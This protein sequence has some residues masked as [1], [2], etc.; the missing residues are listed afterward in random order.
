MIC[1]AC[2][3]VYAPPDD[4][5]GRVETLA[6]LCPTCGTEPKYKRLGRASIEGLIAGSV[7][8]EFL[9]L[10]MFFSNWLKALAYPIFIA[11]LCGAI[12]AI[13]MRSEVI[14]FK[15]EAERKRHM[16]WRRIFFGIVGFGAGFGALFLF[17]E[18]AF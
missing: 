11:L 1:S 17:V 5:I 14:T 15:N 13:S 8:A 7:P 12:Y 4:L 16:L 6:G 10:L 3:S 9:L 2:N 18:V